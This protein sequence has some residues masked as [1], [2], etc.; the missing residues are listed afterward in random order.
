MQTIKRYVACDGRQFDDRFA[1]ARHE[2]Y[3]QPDLYVKLMGKISN[4]HISEQGR[5]CGGDPETNSG[6]YACGCM[7][8]AN[9]AFY[10]LG[11]Q[12]EHWKVWFDELRPAQPC[13]NVPTPHTDVDVILEAVGPERI[14]VYNHIRQST[15]LGLIEAKLLLDKPN[16]VLKSGTDYY[17]GKKLVDALNAAGATA[18]LVVSASEY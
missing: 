18:K 5:W 13:D 7:G 17:T 11:L 1:C 9:G 2:F 10:S 14:I 15:G 8:C 16:A 4:R 6:G 3:V 12:Y